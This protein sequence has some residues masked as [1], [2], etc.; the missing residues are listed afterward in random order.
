MIHHGSRSLFI[1]IGIIIQVQRSILWASSEA[2]GNAGGSDSVEVDI[3]S[4]DILDDHAV[5]LGQ[6]MEGRI[7]G[8][9]FEGNVG[10]MLQVVLGFVNC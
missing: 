10:F 9:V 7:V 8:G 3:I 1:T 5:F 4:L 6:E 2:A